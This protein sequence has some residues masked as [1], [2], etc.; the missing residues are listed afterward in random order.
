MIDDSLLEMSFAI[1]REARRDYENDVNEESLEAYQ[2][3]RGAFRALIIDEMHDQL[4]G[5]LEA[6]LEGAEQIKAAY[7]VISGADKWFSVNGL[8]SGLP[9]GFLKQIKLPS[10]Y[11]VSVDNLCGTKAKMRVPFAD[12]LTSEAEALFEDRYTYHDD[13]ERVEKEI[14][15]IMSNHAKGFNAGLGR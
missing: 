11:S 4:E 10:P 7:E 1:A 13:I 15:T 6:Y 3:A 12:Y 8:K 9:S 5:A 2:K 14:P